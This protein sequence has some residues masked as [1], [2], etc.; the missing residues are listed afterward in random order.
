M[1]KKPKVSRLMRF[2]INH[3][4]PV[5]GAI[6]AFGVVAIWQDIGPGWLGMLLLLGGIGIYATSDWLAKNEAAQEM[7]SKEDDGPESKPDTETIEDP[8]PARTVGDDETAAI[9]KLTK[10]LEERFHVTPVRGVDYRV[11]ETE[12]GYAAEL[13]DRG[14]Q[15]IDAA[16][17]QADDDDGESILDKFARVMGIDESDESDAADDEDREGLLDGLDPLFESEERYRD[18][19]SLEDGLEDGFDQE[20]DFEAEAELELDLEEELE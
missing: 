4:T 11:I 5:A 7:L 8:P 3:P 10:P 18:G 16:A 1:T 9:A 13:T 12:T 17:S 19:A 15:L 20:Y 14:E 2:A 6:G